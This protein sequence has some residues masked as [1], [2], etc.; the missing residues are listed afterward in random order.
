MDQ[1]NKKR[2]GGPL[3]SFSFVSSLH[4]RKAESQRL[5]SEKHSPGSRFK[6]CATIM[7]SKKYEGRRLQSA[8]L[9]SVCAFI[10]EAKCP[11]V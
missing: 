3:S 8:E 6:H 4:S 5:H 2:E 11:L 9:V 10:L 1:Q 7:T